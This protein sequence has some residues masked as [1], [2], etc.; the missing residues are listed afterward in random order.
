MTDR[1]TDKKKGRSKVKT[2]PVPFN[3]LGI[4]ESFIN[5]NIPYESPKEQIINKALKF[6][7]QGNISEA[8]KYYRD[9]I[10]QGFND[11]IVFSNYGTILKELGKLQEAEISTRK[12]IEIK[13]NFAE[14]HYNLGNILKDLGKLKDSELSTRKA[15]KIKHDLAEAHYK[16]GNILIELGNLKE[17][18]ISTRK[19]IEI[20]PNFANS[21]LNLGN[22]LIKLGNLKEAE[23]STRK[24]IELKPNFA[25][26]HN[27]L[28]NLLKDIGKPKEAELSIR[29]A[30]E[31]KP[32][33]AEAHYNL[34]IFLKELGKLKE[35]EL[36]TLKAIKLKPDLA[37]AYSHLGNILRD[38]G[39]IKE[40]ENK[41]LKA[42]EINPSLISPI[43]E[44]ASQLYLAKKYKLAMKYLKKCDSDDCQTLYLGC[45]LC[46]DRRKEFDRKYN[47]LSAKNICNAD[48]SGIIEHA[49]IIYDTSNKS[50]FCNE[51]IQY[52]MVEKIDEELFS[53]NHCN[54]LISYL[55]GDEV[56]TKY[57]SLIHEALQTSGNLF[58]LDY[59]FIKSL[60]KALELKIEL[61]KA[62]F[63]DSD[64]GFIRNWPKDFILNS[65]MLSMKS[66]GFIQQHNHRYGW[67]TGSFY[68]EVPQSYNN[69]DAGNISFSYQGPEYPSKEKKFNS[70]IQ[71]IETR[72]ICIF[73]SSLYHKTIPFEGTKERI[74]LVFDLIK[75]H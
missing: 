1:K 13:P 48:I 39:N 70:T 19:A 21:H 30:I 71:K 33:F 69:N 10:N 34:A 42:I 62:N 11:H 50:N 60:K 8:E 26:A 31:I 55:K 66:G 29:K 44:L 36:S 68:L 24:A 38:L 46:L 18:E 72:D 4:K 28:G 5:T 58:A 40:A 56:E 22:I 17:A 52:V 3:S 2:F 74:C 54:E 20:K 27:N 73:P 14:A 63:K 59:P 67:I 75:K 65:W 7:S 51:A 35:A 37:D 16:L 61:Y 25:E 64:Q 12:A 41:W 9:C 49:N 43:K 15:I 53:T 57:Q 45:L 32:N 6:H 23:I 47:E